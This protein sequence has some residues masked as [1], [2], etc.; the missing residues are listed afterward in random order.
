MAAEVGNAITNAQTSVFSGADVVVIFGDHYVG[1][2]MS[3]TIGVN[4]EAGPLYVMGRKEPIA[5]PKGKRG[6]GGSFILAQLGYDALLE[7]YNDVMGGTANKT[8]V[9]IRNDEM[10]PT[11]DKAVGGQSF[12]SANVQLSQAS[13]GTGTVSNTSDL[14]TSLNSPNYV[15][16]LPPFNI[17]VVGM[18]EQGKKMGF[19]VY[20]VVI[21]NDGIA[22]SIEELN[23]EKKYT[24]IA[25]A[26]SRMQLL[27]G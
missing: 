22:I 10:V 16:Q 3:F 15:D 5:I 18:N 7:H 6:I 9:W 27:Q 14:W 1:E 24:F 8:S 4:R 11:T 26:V 12:S 19:R 23:M 21:I 20:G 13:G 17:T 2:C 25:Q